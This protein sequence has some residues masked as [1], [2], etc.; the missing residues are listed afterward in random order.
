MIASPLSLLIGM[1]LLAQPQDGEGSIGGLV[2]NASRGDAPEGSAEVLLRVKIDDEFVV[3]DR[4]IA[5][6]E[7]RFRFDGIPLDEGLVYLPGANRDGIHYPGPRIRLS[8]AQPRVDIVV[9]VQDS[10]AESNPLFI[11][12]WEL[13]IDP[14]PGALASPRNS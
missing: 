9:K 6:R 14:E 10:I 7:G 11:R 3:V 2:L 5:D 13:E 8:E 12:D 4:V 1:I